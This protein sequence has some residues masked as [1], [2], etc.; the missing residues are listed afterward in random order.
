MN[1][2]NTIYTVKITSA[3]A[4]ATLVPSSTDFIAST[5]LMCNRG[6]E[7]A[8]V[9]IKVADG[10][11]TELGRVVHNREIPAGE[12]K[13]VDVN[14]LCIPPQNQLLV[15]STLINVDFIASGGVKTNLT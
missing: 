1:I 6:S 10:N 3:N 4:D 11:G 15:R 2:T 8:L 9:Q 7:T 12:S 14:S 5:V 13:V